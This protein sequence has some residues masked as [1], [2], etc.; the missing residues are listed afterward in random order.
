[1]NNYILSPKA[2]VMT[3]GSSIGTQDKYFENNKW[4]KL[5]TAG[6]ESTAEYLVS[7]VLK[8]SNVEDYVEYEK[9][10]I[11]G[12][13]GCVSNNFLNEN[14]SFIS[15]ERLYNL[16]RGESLNDII[17]MMD[18]IQER[19]DYVMDFIEEYT[20]LDVSDYLSK[21]LALDALTL[22]VDR[23]FHNLGIIINEK[24][25]SFRTAPIFDNGNAL[26]SNMSR[27]PY[28]NIDENIKMVVGMP[29]SSNL[30]LQAYEVGIGLKIDYEGLYECLKNEPHSRAL[31][32]LM[33]QL[34]RERNLIPDLYVGESL[35]KSENKSIK[36]G[37]SR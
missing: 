18:S 9:C 17:P 29:F 22:N 5:D 13:N 11:N 36:K 35:D 10:T 4:F 33:Y 1:M 23:H 16:Y 8:Y 12:K 6:Y 21:I 7:L 28:A 2:L 15:F 20:G 27:F 37:R 30:E 26:L 25:E 24:E 32:I 34:Q 14:E 19:V 31:D 3:Q